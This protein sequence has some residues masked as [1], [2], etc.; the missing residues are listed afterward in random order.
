M[1][2]QQI[3]TAG[4]DLVDIK[5]LLKRLWPAHAEVSADEIAQAISLFFTGRVSEAQAAS[6]LICLHFT[7]LDRRADVLARCAA[8]MR[9][10]AARVDFGS[11]GEVVK[12]KGRSRGGYEGGLVSTESSH[13][14]G[15]Q[16]RLRVLME[17]RF[18]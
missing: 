7:G 18:P 14:I 17:T 4:P 6:L 13:G 16:S 10:A 12:V 2:A 5:P 15:G 9:A 3:P 8:V 1:A 11:L